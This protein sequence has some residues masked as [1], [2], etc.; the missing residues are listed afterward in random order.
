MADEWS[1]N[2]NRDETQFVLAV[3]G[4]LVVR[5]YNSSIGRLERK[6]Q[7]G[8]GTKPDNLWLPPHTSH[9]GAWEYLP[10]RASTL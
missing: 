5:R 10:D 1:P 3:G 8:G 9:Q 2:A 6:Y 4:V 7:L